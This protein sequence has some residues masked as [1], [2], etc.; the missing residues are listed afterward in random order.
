MVTGSGSGIG[1][2]IAQVFA[3]RGAQVL[4]SDVSEEALAPAR[5]SGLE[6]AVCDVS[7]ETQV[8]ALIEQVRARFGGLDT[9]VN[10]A[11]ISGPTGAVETLD[12]RAWR[13][14]F[15]VNIH[16]Q[17]YCVKHAV[18]LLR[19]SANAS[20]VNMSS[21]AGR[22]GMRGRS[23]Y[24]ATKWAVIGFTKTLAIE[25]GPDQ[26]RVNAICPGVV[27]NDRVRRVI[28][29]KADMLNEPVEAVTE[30]YAGLASMGKMVTEEDIAQA[31]YF[32][33]SPA[34]ASI[35]GQALAVDGN[36]EKLY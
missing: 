26:I 30:Q 34:A 23:P 7:D 25:L 3:A 5:E 17:F 1:L 8:V 24:S 22:L 19:A 18:D 32:L 11:G 31:A 16:G 21:A 36:T 2:R 4:A 9:L 6:T 20:I 14:T 12:S 27:D 33:A 13:Q 15:E 28:A 10:N 35:S 29:A